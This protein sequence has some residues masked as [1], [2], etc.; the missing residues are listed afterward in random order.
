MPYVSSHIS[1]PGTSQLNHALMHF[2]YLQVLDLLTT[3]AFLVNGIKEANP[4]VRFFLKFGPNPISGLIVVKFLAILLGV[5]CWRMGRQRLLSRINVM[6]AMVIAWNLV[7][8]IV[9]ALTRT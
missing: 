5:Y 4:V 7:A 1:Q 2:S 8:L 9:G 3:V 6:F